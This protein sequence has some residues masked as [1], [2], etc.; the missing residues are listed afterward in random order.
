MPAYFVCFRDEMKNA[1]EYAAY[2]PKAMGTFAGHDSKLIVANGGVTPLEGEAPDG[3]VIIEFPTVQAAKDW[4]HSDAYQAVIGQRLGAT[5]G[6]SVI[7]EGF[8]PG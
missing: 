2:G 8:P 4:Y 3:V 6:R 1:A 5:V 7:V